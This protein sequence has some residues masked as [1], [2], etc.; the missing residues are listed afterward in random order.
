M[1]K[2]SK[3]T[4]IEIKDRSVTFNKSDESVPF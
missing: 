3:P 1:W 4:K 2:V